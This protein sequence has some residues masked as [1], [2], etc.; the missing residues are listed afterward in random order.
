MALRIGYVLPNSWGLP[1]PREDVDLAV[2]AEELGAGSL[3]VSHHVIHTGFVAERL[4]T[5]NYYDP[6]VS[7]TAAALA[8]S[9]VRLGTSVLV[10]GYLNPFVTAKQ[11]ATIDWLSRGRVDVGVGVGGLREEF[12]ATK[13]VPF[14]RRG[15]YADEFMDVMRLLWSPGKS[16]FGG[17]FFSFEEV[18][19]YPGPFQPG[20][21][22]ILIGGNGWRAIRRTAQRGDGWHGIG[23]EPEAVPELR[24]RL[25]EQLA[26]QGKDS[27]GFPIQL[28][29]HIDPDDLDRKRWHDRAAAYRDA[30]LTDLI[31]APQTR[32]KDAHLRWLETLLPVLS[33]AGG[34]P[35]TSSS[36]PASSARR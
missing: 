8:T 13:V 24:R 18:E 34:G 5:G 31:L 30:G 12:E 11:L 20:G 9:R 36:G 21:L 14:D 10:L 19:A 15:E 22:P 6:L 2:L 28:R 1:D 17:E 27:E 3:W 29:L 25:F 4:G 32:D 33:E 16:R 26:V 7:L 35:G 23:L